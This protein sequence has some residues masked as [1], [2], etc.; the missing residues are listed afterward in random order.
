MTEPIAI[1]PTIP[2]NTESTVVVSN[3]LK[4]DT[5]IVSNTVSDNTAIFENDT[6][7][8]LVDAVNNQDAVRKSQVE[9]NAFPGGVV[10]NIQFRNSGFAGSSNFT[11]NDGSTTLTVNGDIVDLTGMTISGDTISN[12]VDPVNDNDIAT[13]SFVDN[14]SSTS[15]ITNISS[16]INQTWTA[17]SM[18]GVIIRN[19]ASGAASNASVTDTTPTAAQIIAAYPGTPQVGSTFRFM[20]INDNINRLDTG[21]TAADDDLFQVTFVGGTGVTVVPSGSFIV[22]R[23]HTLDAFVIFDNVTGGTEA[24]TININSIN[25]SV[26]YY[27]FKPTN[28]AVN[29]YPIKSNVLTGVQMF[30]SGNQFFSQ[31]VSSSDSTIGYTYGDELAKGYSLRSPGAGSADTFSITSIVNRIFP[32]HTFSITNTGAGSISISSTDLGTLTPDPL[33]V[34]SNKT[35]T[36]RIY[37]ND[38]STWVTAG[39]SGSGGYTVGAA[40]TTGGTG[41]GMTL[42]ILLVASAVILISGGTGYTTGTYNTTGGSGSGLQ[43]P[44]YEV[45]GS[46]TVQ[47]NGYK[48]FFTASDLAGYTVGDILTLSGGDNNA[49]FGV[50]GIE[51]PLAF[52]VT[53][54][55]DNLYAQSDV[56]TIIQGGSG[57]DATFTLSGEVFSVEQIMY[58]DAV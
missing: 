43:I 31:D 21:G 41:T 15:T 33:V 53:S 9:A 30:M 28:Y 5:I 35:A 57:N 19:S 6:L 36:F 22:P 12:V 38:I 44:V 16:D 3:N 26:K 13:K 2:A 56:I 8:N 47:V 29:D 42:N 48:T 10:D 51:A 50:A 55:G 58:A 32:S 52:D 11:Y 24:V 23:T 40:T 1:G 17:A 27:F 34:A 7:T 25:W 54:F 49:T 46:G 4:A 37:V 20:L 39:S 45:N 14:L 18:Y